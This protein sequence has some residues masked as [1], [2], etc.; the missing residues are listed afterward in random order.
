MNIRTQTYPYEHFRRTE[1][2]AD[3]EILE[4]TNS[5]SL[6]PYSYEHFRMIEHPEDLESH[7]W[8]LVVD[9]NAAYH[10]THNVGKS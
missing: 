10:L 7:Q 6:K 2:P 3:L 8:R 4:A 5:A 1:H 9:R